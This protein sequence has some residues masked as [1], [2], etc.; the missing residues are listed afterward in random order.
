MQNSQD[1]RKSKLYGKIG[2]LILQAVK[3]GGPDAVANSRLKDVLKQAQQAAIPRDII[4]RNIKN[5][6]DKSQA[7]FQ[8]VI[9]QSTQQ[10]CVTCHQHPLHMI[11][12]SL[13]LCL[14]T[15]LWSCRGGSPGLTCHLGLLHMHLTLA[16]KQYRHCTHTQDRQ[17]HLQFFSRGV[18]CDIRWSGT[19][20][21]ANVQ[22][23]HTVCTGR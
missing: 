21:C 23:R 18:L 6:S 3:A 15:G 12:H 10:T 8:E 22:L 9:A 14:T 4:D 16:A 2:K 11:L 20:V 1:M 13:A 5:G 19:C 17:S 7:D